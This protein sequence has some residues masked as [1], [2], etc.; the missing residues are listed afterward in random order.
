M[1]KLKLAH[2]NEIYHWGVKGMKWGVRRYQNEDGTLTAAGKARYNDDGSVKDARTMTDD[3]LNSANKRLE[4]EQK[5]RSLT[6][7]TQPSKAAIS[8]TAIKVG[9]SVV[10]S[11]GAT[12]LVNSL[13]PG[14]TATGKALVQKI[15]LN[16]GLAAISTGV[17]VFGGQERH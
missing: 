15:L 7:R 8:D 6:G 12:L 4:A 13:S 2:Y 11:V 10:A 9:A 1:D 5:Y 3:E 14:N 16:S 17:A